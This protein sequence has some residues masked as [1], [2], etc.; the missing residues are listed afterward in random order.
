MPTCSLLQVNPINLFSL[1]DNKIFC[2][3]QEDTTPSSE[4][5]R[6]IAM[7]KLRTKKEILKD[8]AFNRKFKRKFEG[9]Q[10]IMVDLFEEL[11]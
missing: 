6:K 10:D 8:P 2:S 1:L 5:L 4:E 7:E 11:L 3:P 9:N